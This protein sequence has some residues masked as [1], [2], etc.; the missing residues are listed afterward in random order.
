MSGALERRVDAALA[1]SPFAARSAKVA[2]LLAEAPD[3]EP[4]LER[5]SDR[6]LAGLARAAATNSEQARFAIRRRGV[7]ARAAELD[8]G[9]PARRAAQLDAELAQAPAELEDLLDAIR[10]LRREEMLLAACVDFSGLTDFEEISQLLSALAEAIVRRAFDAAAGSLRGPAP[11]L[12]VV[13][14]GKLG[15]REFTYHSDLDLIFLGEG[16]V[17]AVHGASRIAQRLI[18]YVSTT[19]GAGFAYAVDSRL[20]PSGSQGMLVTSFEGFERYQS[21][22]AATWEYLA[23][24]RARAIAGARPAAETVLERVKKRAFGCGGRWGEVAEMRARIEAERAGREGALELKTGAGGLMDV[25]FLAEGAVLELGMRHTGVP[26]IPDL[27]RACAGSAA[28]RTL[29]HYHLLRRVESRMRWCAGRAVESLER[30]DPRLDEVAELVEPGLRAPE[31][32]ARI[33][34]SRAEIRQ[35]FEAVTR[36]GTIAALA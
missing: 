36:A 7:L 12:A 28:E 8:A 10:L 15:G 5:V 17:E 33:A 16:G 13:A 29:R 21:S 27:L 6:I 2:A 34:A 25:E 3:A 32:V 11:V 23:L 24:V 9:W 4:A 35:A 14:M 26:G 22:E 30:S 19:T 18:S 20:R 1:A 31:L